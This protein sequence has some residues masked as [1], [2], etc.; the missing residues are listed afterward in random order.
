[1]YIEGEE[2]RKESGHRPRGYKLGLGGPWL[3]VGAGRSLTNMRRPGKSQDGKA[4]V[5]PP[6]GAVRKASSKGTA[7]GQ[8]G[9]QPGWESGPVLPSLAE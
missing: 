8:R 4:T 5:E 6:E 9:G 2:L 1:M 7:T 3:Q